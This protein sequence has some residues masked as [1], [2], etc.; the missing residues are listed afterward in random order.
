MKSNKFYQHQKIITVEGNIA[1]GQY[2]LKDDNGNVSAYFHCSNGYLTD[3]ISE[4]GTIVE[5]AF[6]DVNE[7]HIEHW[8]NGVLHCEDGPAV[9]DLIDDYEEWWYEGKEV[10]NQDP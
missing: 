2:E 8:K 3:S 1:N 9:I 5:P 7:T 4:D 10:E 6:Y